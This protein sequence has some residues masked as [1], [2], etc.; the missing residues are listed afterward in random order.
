MHTQD[1]VSFL[2]A[3]GHMREV[4]LSLLKWTA[5]SLFVASGFAQLLLFP[6][7]TWLLGL[8]FALCGYFWTVS[9]VKKQRKEVARL[10]KAR[11]A[12]ALMGD[13]MSKKT[14]LDETAVAGV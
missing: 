9:N 7:P 4:L 12:I 10:T 8:L 13:P 6:G 14:S 11:G 1:V 2:S 3:F 5:A